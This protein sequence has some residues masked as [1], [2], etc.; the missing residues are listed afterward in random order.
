MSIELIGDDYAV[1]VS[2]GLYSDNTPMVKLGEDF[3]PTRVHTMVLRHSS[4][5]EFVAAMFLVDSIVEQGG[6]VENLVLPYYPGAR[7][8]R[9]NP[10]GDV[11]FSASSFAR[12]INSMEFSRVLILDPHSHVVPDFLVNEVEV[13]PLSD[14]AERMWKGY[15]GIIAPDKGAQERAEIFAAAMGLPIYYASKNRD[16]STGQLSGFDVSVPEGGHY[17]V[18]DD[19]CDGGGT[20]V[21]L[22]EK[23]REQGAFADLYVT[24]GIFAKGTRSLREFYKN[25]YTTDSLEQDSA[26]RVSVIPVI[27]RM[28]NYV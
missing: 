9:I 7:Q 22:G 26:D 20:F 23:I 3:D 18:V 27:E 21:G 17:L 11:L 5:T 8:D 14:I 19:I 25:I 12:I 1:T 24:H 6:Y 4:T 16:V 28:K 15:T 2:M 13:F 10:T